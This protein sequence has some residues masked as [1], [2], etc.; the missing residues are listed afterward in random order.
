MAAR[1]RAARVPG[2]ITF[3][4]LLMFVAAGLHLVYGLGEL[5]DSVWKFDHTNGIFAGDLWVWGIIDVVVAVVLALAAA[6]LIRGGETGRMIAII[7]VVLSAIR[8]LY[9]IPAAPLMAV[10]LLI[11]DAF[12]LYGLTAHGEFFAPARARR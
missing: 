12:I 5:T 2:V 10:V 9:W 11:I 1:R 3:A 8:F 7:W 6:D 4:A